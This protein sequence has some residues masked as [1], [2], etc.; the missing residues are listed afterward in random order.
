MIMKSALIVILEAG[1]E[2]FKMTPFEE[3]LNMNI[4]NKIIDKINLILFKK[5][6]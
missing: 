1:P 3:D 6:K 4:Q 5:N 2:I